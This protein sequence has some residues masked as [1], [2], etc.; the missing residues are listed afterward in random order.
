[1]RIL[2]DGI[3][4]R[5]WLLCLHASETKSEKCVSRPA[6]PAQ[7]GLNLGHA[8]TKITFSIVDPSLRL[9]ALVETAASVQ[10]MIRDYRTASRPFWVI[11]GYSETVVHSLV[12]FLEDSEISVRF[13]C[14][15]V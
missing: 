8:A 13:L 9:G 6:G 1:M 5:S 7:K 12:K 3:P 2:R 14:E 10:V 4:G 11:V 15:A